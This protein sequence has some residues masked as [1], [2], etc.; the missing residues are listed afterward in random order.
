MGR[1]ILK[2]AALFIPQDALDPN[3]ADA[4]GKLDGIRIAVCVNYAVVVNQNQIGGET[5]TDE[6]AIPQTQSARGLSCNVIHR[7]FERHDTQ[8]AHILYAGGFGGL[9]EIIFLDSTEM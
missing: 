6:A 5:F 1:R 9:T 4:C 7:G 8:V 2:L 3:L